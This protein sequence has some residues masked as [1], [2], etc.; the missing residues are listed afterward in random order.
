EIAVEPALAAHIAVAD[1]MADRMTIAAA[2]QPTDADAVP[3]DRL[4]AEQHGGGVVDGEAGKKA[5]QR[6]LRGFGQRRT[7]LKGDAAPP[8]HRPAE[9]CDERRM[10]GANI[11]PPGAV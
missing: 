2:R 8:L 4:A 6:C 9:P 10:I 3:V 1:R 7:T 5:R 11:A